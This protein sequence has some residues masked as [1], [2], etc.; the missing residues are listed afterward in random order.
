MWPHFPSWSPVIPP[1]AP[2]TTAHTHARDA[3]LAFFS[4][5]FSR[6][7]FL[8]FFFCLSTF[9]SAPSTFLPNCGVSETH[10]PV[11]L[12]LYIGIFYAFLRDGF[13]A[14]SVSWLASSDYFVWLLWVS[15]FGSLF[16][17]CRTSDTTKKRRLKLQKVGRSD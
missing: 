7:L 2:S 13:I 10:R 15:L 3:L 5:L 11:A 1:T 4:R 9:P 14:P 8:P 17:C 16:Y 12:S 6:F